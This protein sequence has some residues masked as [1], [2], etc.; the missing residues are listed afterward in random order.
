MKL[1]RVGPKGHVPHRC[2]VW[3]YATTR[4]NPFSDEKS[5][6]ELLQGFADDTPRKV[7]VIVISG[8]TT[9]NG[10]VIPLCRYHVE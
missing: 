9:R 6:F 4:G 5:A 3:R 10:R 1:K 2:K 7:A 8:T